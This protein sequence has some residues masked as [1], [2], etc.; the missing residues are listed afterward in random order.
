MKILIKRSRVAQSLTTTLALAF[1]TLSVIALLISGGLQLYS[2]LQTQQIIIAGN[3]QLIAQEAARTVSSFIQEKFGVLETAVGLTN[4]DEVSRPEQQEVLSGLLGRQPA[5]RQLVLFNAHGQAL[6]QVSR[7]A[8][9]EPRRFAGRLADIVPAQNL[10]VNRTISPVYID[11]VTSEPL[12][13]MTVPVVDIFGDFRGTLL[14]EVNLKF[15]WDLISQLQVGRTGYAYVV[16][17]DGNLIAFGDMA[18]VL[19][20]EN[21]AYLPAVHE[22][23][24]HSTS[25]QPN[26][27]KNYQ[28]IMGARVVGTYAPL[29]TPDWAVVTEIPWAETYRDVIREAVWAGA[30]TLVVATLASLLG[31]YLAHRLVVPLVNLTTVAAQIAGGERKLQAVVEGPREVASLAVAFNSMTTQ[32]RQTLEGLEQQITERRRAEESLRQTN[33]TLQALVDHS[34]LAINMVDLDSRVLLWNRAAERMYGWTAKEVLGKFLPNISPETLE[35]YRAIRERV[36]EGESITNLE[37]Q[38]QRKDGSMF[39]LNLSVAPLRDSKGNVYA[40]IAIGADISARKQA[41]SEREA[42]IAELEAKNAELER[43]IYTISHDLKSPLITIGGFVGF[44]E[45]DALAGNVER[46]SADMAHIN[47]AVTKM[48]RLLNELLELSRIGRWANPPEEASFEEIAGEAIALV[49]GRIEASGVAVEIAPGL[50]SVYGD[51]ARLVE[52]VQNLVDNA[53]KFMGNQPRPRLQIGARHEDDKTVFYVRDNGMGIEPRYHDKVFGL[54]DKLDPQSEGTGVGL[55]LV[56][57]IIE[58]HGG[59]VWVDSSGQGS[60]TTFYFTLPVKKRD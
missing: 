32:L 49:R 46:V 15:M 16:D 10:P 1:F 18:R 7:L 39:W 51:R 12:L 50:P 40:Q 33:E 38:R 13:I 57:R 9:G 45:R 6:T 48:Q 47:N 26:W 22:F 35:E 23:I 28:G 36:T 4:L 8:L 37:V 30:I 29:G 19:R 3:Q 24:H 59:R 60:G 58:T 43:F 2:N 56:K 53:C 52:V 41:E 5:F 34:P 21:V 17:R 20:G 55:A 25:T 11:P 14:A 27:G 42:L 44:L 54:F 31:V